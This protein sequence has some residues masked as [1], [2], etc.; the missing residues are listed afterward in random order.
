MDLI[1]EEA[2]EQDIPDLTRVMTL[3][4][5]DDARKHLGQEKGGPPGYDNGEFFRVWL[6]P[7]KESVG[8]KILSAGT[9]IGFVLVWILP[10]G[11]NILG[12]IFVHPDHQDQ[13]VG[14]RAWQFVEEH[15]PETTSWTL[16]TPG[17]ASKN[18]H[19]YEKCGF[20]KIREEQQPDGM[21]LWVYQKVMQAA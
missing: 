1:F 10:Q 12:T 17:W 21:I 15:Y 14:S 6:L 5:D 18:H 19:F 4:F 7:Y 8:Y 13:G 11:E 16:H 20:R 9:L 3:A 2:T